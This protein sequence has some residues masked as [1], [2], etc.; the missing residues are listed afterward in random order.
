MSLVR[1]EPF[2]ELG[3]LH[4]QMN[5]LFDDF[6]RGESLSPFRGEGEGLWQP[7][8]EIQETDT[9]L[10]VKAQIPGVSAED[11]DIEVSENALTISGE[12]REEARSED[13]GIVRSEFRYGHFRRS[14]PFTSRVRHEEVTSDYT[15]GVLTLTLP[16]AESAR[17]TVKVKVVSSGNGSKS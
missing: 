4:R 8:I 7:A 3:T 6:A 16:K 14:I 13:E 10:I 12:H 5:R 11:L 2:S 17:R 9:D 1:W 15:D